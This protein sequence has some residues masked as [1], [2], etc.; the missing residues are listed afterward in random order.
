MTED[1]ELRAT[2]LAM[3]IRALAKADEGFTVGEVFEAAQLFHGF[4]T[5]TETDIQRELQLGKSVMSPETLE[6]VHETKERLSALLRGEI[7]K[8]R[9]D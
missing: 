4:L 2:A 1:Q 3:A 5:D 8:P 6:E 9:P 7:W